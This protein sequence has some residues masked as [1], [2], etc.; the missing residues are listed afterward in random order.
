M[1]QRDRCIW[2]GV[3]LLPPVE[4]TLEHYS[5][6][7]LGD[8]PPDSRNWAIAC[9]TCNN[10]K[11]DALAWASMPEAHDYFGRTQ[12][13]G[14]SRISQRH[15]WAVLMR[16]RKC[17]MCGI[18]PNQRELVIIKRVRTGLPIP[19]NCAAVCRNCGVAHKSLVLTAEWAPEEA[20]RQ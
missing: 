18:E 8:D 9:K 1:R 2:C 7:H 16:H 19:A 3:E 5:P 4:E 11:G 15:R 13:S 17:V 12:L 10:G 14:A 6:K 20:A